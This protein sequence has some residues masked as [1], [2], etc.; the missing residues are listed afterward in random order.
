M[1]DEEV[2][3]AVADEGPSTSVCSEP[4]CLICALEVL[5]VRAK[6]AEAAISV[7]P[8]VKTVADSVAG[9]DFEAGQQEDAHEFVRSLMS[10]IQRIELKKC[11]IPL[12]HCSPTQRSLLERT[13]MLN[14][15]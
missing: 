12:Q 1:E 14:Q 15:V 7:T 11:R 3:T 13:T 2:K 5:C 8:L 10:T 6:R 4:E 9:V